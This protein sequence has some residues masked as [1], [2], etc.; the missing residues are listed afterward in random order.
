[1]INRQSEV[2]TISLDEKNVDVSTQIDQESGSTNMCI[3]G[4][5]AI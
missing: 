1:M 2:A 5:K 3:T 4:L